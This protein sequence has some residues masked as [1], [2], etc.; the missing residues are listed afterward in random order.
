MKIPILA[1]AA[2]LAATLPLC[3][4]IA[5]AQGL[6]MTDGS[7]L[8]S[9]GFGGGV[10]VPTGDASNTFKDGVTGQAFVLVHLGPLPSLRFNLGYDKFDYKDALGLPGAHTN[11]LSGTGGLSI[12]LIGG[13]IRPYITAALGAFD[14]NSVVNAV[15]T[16]SVSKVNFGIDGG[17]GISI[18]FGR[19]SGFAEGRVQNVYT[20]NGGVISAKSIQSIPVSFGLLFGL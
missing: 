10:I 12:D 5:G 14:V 3:T 17:G 13:P 7:H 2:A 1:R 8:I 9:L 6:P 16:S 19:V 15:N 11:I 20:R 4:S 18:H